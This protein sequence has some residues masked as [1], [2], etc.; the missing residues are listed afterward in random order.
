MVPFSNDNL[1]MK[2]RA[3]VSMA[4]PHGLVMF[5]PLVLCRFL[6]QHDLTQGDVLEAFMRD[7]AVGDAAVQAGCIV[8]MYPLDEDDYLFCN[9]DAEPLA[10]DWQFSHGGLPL[11]VESGV[12]VVADLFVLVGWEHAAFTRYE[13]QRKLSWTVND[14]DVVPGSHAVR[15]R[16]AR[17]EGDG[18]QGAKV[19]GLQLALLAPGVTPSGRP[20]WPHS[21]ALDFGIA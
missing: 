11:V 4:Y 10:L 19:F 21:D 18:L 2:T 12:L 20:I 14:L 15:I 7:E 9:L 8:P 3:T 1:S 5:D 17:G 6:E 13:R 16:G